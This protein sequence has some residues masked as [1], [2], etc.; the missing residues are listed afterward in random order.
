LQAREEEGQTS[1]GWKRFQRVAAVGI[2]A[3]VAG[4]GLQMVFIGNGELSGAVP[5]LGACTWLQW[6]S[7]RTKE[8]EGGVSVE[9]GLGRR[10]AAGLFFFLFSLFFSVN[11]FFYSCSIFL[12]RRRGGFGKICK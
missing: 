3:R 11:S 8:E 1:V 6:M 10:W 9:I 2:E 12:E 7:C 5:S 4:L